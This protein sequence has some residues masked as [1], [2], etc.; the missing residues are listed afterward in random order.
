MNNGTPV[1]FWISGFFFPQAFLTSTLQAHARKYNLPLDELSFDSNVIS[2]YRDQDTYATRL[3][4]LSSGD[5][6]KDD[7]YV[8]NS[9]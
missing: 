7:A 9:C 6:L 5:R 8:S 4:N 2:Q 1:S 3:K